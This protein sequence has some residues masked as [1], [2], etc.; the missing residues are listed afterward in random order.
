M[1]LISKQI[2]DGFSVKLPDGTVIAAVTSDSN[3]IWVQWEPFRVYRH[4]SEWW[5]EGTV[6]VSEG[7][8]SFSAYDHSLPAGLFG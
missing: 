5:V 6:V 4:F 3:I 8:G 2:R 1:N 7:V